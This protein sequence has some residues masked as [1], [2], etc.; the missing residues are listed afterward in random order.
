MAKKFDNG[1][2]QRDLHLS[3]C[4][5]GRMERTIFDDVFY[6]AYSLLSCTDPRIVW[7]SFRFPISRKR[8][9]FFKFSFEKPQN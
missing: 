3:G 6:T 9:K 2:V 7:I 8:P 1:D 5:D 4:D